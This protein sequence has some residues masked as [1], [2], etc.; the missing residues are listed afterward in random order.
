MSELPSRSH[1]KPEWGDGTA[2]ADPDRDQ[3]DRPAELSGPGAEQDLHHRLRFLELTEPD[4]AVLRSLLPQFQSSE[5]EFVDAFY[6]HLRSFPETAAFLEDPERFARLHQLQRNHFRTLLEARWNATYVASRRRVGDVHA[7][8]GI[9]PQFFIGA[10][11]Q[12]VQYC[13]RHYFENQ[14]G[15]PDPSSCETA[16]SLLKAVFLDIGLTLDAYFLQSTQKLQNAL[17][18]LWKANQDLRQFA[19]LTSHDLKTPLATVANLCEET[20]DEFGSQLPDEARK[21]IDA[22]RERIFRMSTMIDELLSST[23]AS[24]SLDHREEVD[25]TRSINEALDRVRP[26]AGQKGV[27]LVVQLTAPPIWG[28]HVRLREAVYNLASNAVKYS[29]AEQGLVT[30]RSEVRDGH[31]R[32]S[33]ADNGP[34]IPKDELLRVFAPFHRLTTH[35]DLPGTGLGLYFAKNL[36]EALGGRITVESQPGCGCTFSIDLPMN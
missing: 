28:N 18:L 5:G 30:V 25:L 15:A 29:P 21:L 31:V 7:E 8:V 13:L 14:S 27:R 23:V 33:V 1:P 16:L 32:I 20:L 2:S 17:D 36:V 24:E 10:Y 22:A 12:Y 3:L 34:G 9:E 6:R 19:H 35:R 11:Y 26:L 4:A